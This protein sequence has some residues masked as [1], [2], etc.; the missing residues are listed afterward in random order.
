LFAGLP[1]PTFGLLKKKSVRV[2]YKKIPHS[3]YCFTQTVIY[4][5]KIIVHE[6]TCE[7]KKGSKAKPLK[8]ELKKKACAKHP[9]NAP[10]TLTKVLSR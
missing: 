8:K 3:F 6:K 2:R 5:K 4:F 10:L 9:K 1:F 7:K